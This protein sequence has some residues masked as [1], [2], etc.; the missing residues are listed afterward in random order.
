MVI[1]FSSYNNTYF[2]IFMMNNNNK[3]LE[4]LIWEDIYETHYFINP[5]LFNL[6]NSNWFEVKNN[7]LERLFKRMLEQKNRYEII[8]EYDTENYTKLDIAEAEWISNGLA[9][10]WV[11]DKN[12][13]IIIR[14]KLIK[15]GLFQEYNRSI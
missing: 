6:T 8:L 9:G 11:I 7:K 14:E 12:K 2:I 1:I 4:L 13:T 3:N 10:E 15:S 5:K